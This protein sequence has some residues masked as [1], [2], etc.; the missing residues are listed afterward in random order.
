MHPDPQAVA[1]CQKLTLKQVS[2]GQC[3]CTLCDKKATIAMCWIPNAAA[4]N[5]LFTPLGQ[6]HVF[7]YGVCKRCE[8]RLNA[9]KD[10]SLHNLISQRIIKNLW[11]CDAV[12]TKQESLPAIFPN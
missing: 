10:D 11:D 4:L 1:I 9:S 2:S 6:S 3:R 7:G 12:M 5:M 8:K